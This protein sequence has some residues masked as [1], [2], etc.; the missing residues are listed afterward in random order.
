MRNERHVLSLGDADYP[1]QLAASP[2]PPRHLYVLGDPSRLAPGFAVVGARRATPYGLQAAKIFSGWAARS[3]YTVVSGGAVGCD[4]AAH[5]A[6]LQAGGQTVAVMAGGADVA[7]PRGSG[8]LLGEIAR[9]GCV[10]SEH[11]WGTEPRRWAFRTRNRIIAW[12]SSALLVVEATLPS[13]TFSTA[14]YMIDA[15]R[16]V[17]AVPGSIFSDES[18]GPNRLLAQGAT[19]VSDVSELAMALASALGPARRTVGHPALV[20]P[21][22]GDVVVRAVRAC[23]A[24]PDDLARDLALD[25]LE[26]AR[27]LGALEVAGVVVRYRDGR[28]GP[29]ANTTSA[30]V[31]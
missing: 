20:Q 17:L 10:V 8:P 28:Y 23:A 21:D 1:E 12:L 3:G 2:D 30:P 24:R 13:G 16:D 22:E 4:Q 11:P 29:A 6:A 5:N 7:Y 25:V 31:H 9:S 14:D 18:R 26:V 27:R 15:G 19:P